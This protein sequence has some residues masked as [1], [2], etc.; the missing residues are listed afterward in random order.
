GQSVKAGDPLI[1]LD[2]SMNQADR[3]HMQTDLVAAQLDIARLNA[4][5]TG[6]ADPLADFHPPQGASAT[7]VA[8]QREFLL[9]QMAEHRA[10]LA[11]LDRQRAQKEA[12]R[13]TTQASIGKLQ[14]TIPLLQQRV[15]VRKYLFDSALGS[16]LTYLS[17]LQDL[18][19]QQQ[20]LLVQ[21]S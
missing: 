13:A 11:G 8:M 2:A 16:K 20:D 3:E 15:D 5:L 7:L 1:E 21:T 19:G 9:S 12:E 10:K 6:S 4:A 17:E 18:V 14:A